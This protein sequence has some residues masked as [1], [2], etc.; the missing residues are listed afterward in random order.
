MKLSTKILIVLLAALMLF[1]STA[2][3]GSN[4]LTS[5]VRDWNMGLTESAGWRATWGFFLFPVYWVTGIVD[6]IIFN[7]WEYWSGT[8]PINGKQ[9]FVD[10]DSPRWGDVD[11]DAT[12][13]GE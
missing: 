11:A 4:G 1:G 13:A 3:L 10:R 2:C 6:V 8:N 9:R 7:S 5:E 12:P